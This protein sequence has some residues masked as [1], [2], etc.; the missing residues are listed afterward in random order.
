M[1]ASRPSPRP[2]LIGAALALAGCSTTGDP[3]AVAGATRRAPSDRA[4]RLLGPSRPRTP[5]LVFG[6]ASFRVTDNGWSADIS[7]ANRSEVGWKIVERN[8]AGGA[9]VRA[10]V[11]PD[12]RPEGIRAP[13]QHLQRA[14]HQ[15]R[16]ELRARAP[17]GPRARGDVAR[18]HLRARRA[19]WRSL[20]PV[21]FRPVLERRC[22]TQGRPATAITWYTDHAY[23]LEEVAAV[24]A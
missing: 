24:P 16:N 1:D 2:A 20:G 4:A 8:D 17:G 12:R 9:A 13:R 21:R 7:V 6:V 18:N 10:D 3:A 23:H 22:S 5:A 19:P 15:T 14:R 11:V